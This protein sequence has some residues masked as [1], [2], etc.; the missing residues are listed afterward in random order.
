MVGFRVFDESVLNQTTQDCDG[1]GGLDNAEVG[2]L[3]SAPGVICEPLDEL[4]FYCIV[5]ADNT[6]RVVMMMTD[7]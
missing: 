2:V 1:P 5:A 4:W 3:S 7:R 6:R